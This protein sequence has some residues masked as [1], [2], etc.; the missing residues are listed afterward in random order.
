MR[1][2]SENS[3]SRMPRTKA[4]MVEYARMTIRNQSKAFRSFIAFSVVVEAGSSGDKPEGL[5]ILLAGA[6]DD[7]VGKRRRRGLLV[8]VNRFEVVADVLLVEGGLRSA[9]IVGLGGP[10]AGGVRGEDL[11]GEG[12][13]SSLSRRPNSN[14][15]S[16][17]MSPL[18]A[19]C[20]PAFS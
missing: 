12:D 5:K 7:V 16:A 8:P 18:L 10:V 11:V 2:P 4:R 1:P 14:L 3:S 17:R 20:L 13:L 19:A 15:V 9:R 6:G